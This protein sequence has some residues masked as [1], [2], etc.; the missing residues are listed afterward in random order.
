MRDLVVKILLRLGLYKQ[1][2]VWVNRLKDKRGARY[3]KR[4]GREM[5]E[6]AD[7]A[8]SAAGARPFLLFGSLLGAHREKGFI[9]NDADIDL[10]VI[11]TEVSEEMHEKMR[12]AGFVLYRQNYFGDTK[13]VFES[14]Y[15]YKDLFLDVFYG[16]PEGD[17]YCFITACKHE[18]KEWKEAND[19]DGFPCIKSRVPKCDFER[20]E[21]LGLQ[22]YMPVL[23]HE[24]LCDIYSASYM[25]PVK[26][27]DP[28][29]HK[30]RTIPIKERSYRKNF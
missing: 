24:W 16:L 28:N 7:S 8:L 2:V 18:Y 14:T 30:T 29:E 26:H 12:E 5:L 19:S 10:G 3:M 17:D 13:Q 1:T 25:T 20:R 23:T 22:I 9:R 4:Y 15:K 21:F 11:V 6:K 27:W